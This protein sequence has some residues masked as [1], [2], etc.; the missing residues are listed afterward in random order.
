M[1]L[2]FG[3]HLPKTNS[4]SLPEIIAKIER[5]CAY[6]DRCSHDV[7][8]KLK[9]WQI[10][11][12]DSNEILHNLIE[13]GFVN[14]ERFVQSFIRGKA[15]I[16]HWGK[17]KIRIQLIQKGI[18]IQLINQYLETIDETSYQANLQSTIDKWKRSHGDITS[19]NF[20]KIYR[21]LLSKGYN[22]SET[23]EAINQNK[24]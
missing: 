1:K 7:L 14:D 9:T 11:E 23:L 15:N 18:G 4:M 6:Q 5:Y 20:P 22:N 24:D 16:K 21:H 2:C 17:T 3:Q 19:E 13:N 10:N 8:S 12:A